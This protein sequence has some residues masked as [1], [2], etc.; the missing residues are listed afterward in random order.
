MDK[1]YIHTNFKAKGVL[2]DDQSCHQNIHKLNDKDESAIYD[3]NK[4]TKQL[5][6]NQIKVLIS[7]LVNPNIKVDPNPSSLLENR[8]VA[9]TSEDNDLQSEESD[10]EGLSKRVKGQKLTQNQINY[11]KEYAQNWGFTSKTICQNF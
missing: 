11:I 2:E 9:Y 5:D 6:V 3:V 1:L 4:I 10:H 8:H 7:Q